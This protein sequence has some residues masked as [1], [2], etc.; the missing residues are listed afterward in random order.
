MALIISRCTDHI[1]CSCP[2]TLSFSPSIVTNWSWKRNG[3]DEGPSKRPFLSQTCCWV[4][5]TAISWALDKAPFSRPVVFN[6]CV[7]TP[8]GVTYQIPC[9][10][11]IY[12]MSHSNS[13]FTVMKQQWKQFVWLRVTTWGTVLEGF[14]IRKAENHWSRW[15]KAMV[16]SLLAFESFITLV[17][18]CGDSSK[19]PSKGEVH[20]VW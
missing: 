2:S 20:G 8:L 14:S 3:D 19:R 15:R 10:S 18:H 17:F 5:W 1:S 9:I 16:G 12:I 11:D 4:L 13:K 7:M 6:L